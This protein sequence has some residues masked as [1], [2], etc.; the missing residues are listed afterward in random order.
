MG[1]EGK[2]PGEVTLPGRTLVLPPESGGLILAGLWRAGWAAEHDGD[3]EAGAT[4]R[5]LRLAL[6]YRLLDGRGDLIGRDA[7]CR[8]YPRDGWCI[9]ELA[10][11]P[12]PGLVDPLRRGT[13]LCPPF[14]N[15]A[16]EIPRWA[17]PLPLGATAIVAPGDL[18]TARHCFRR[19]RPWALGARRAFLRIAAD[20]ER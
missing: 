12:P 14:A 15:N 5:W 6:A 9:V 20:G 19:A 16:G 18:V 4:R 8:L 7:L 17:V 11:P 2:R 13:V 1:A 3:R 10:P